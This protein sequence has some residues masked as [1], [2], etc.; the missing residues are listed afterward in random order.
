MFGGRI[1]QLRA[2]RGLSQTALAGRAGI[3][4]DFLAKVEQG[5][6]SP[7]LLRIWEIAD[8]LEVAPAEL[9]GEG[10]PA[11]WQRR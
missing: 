3:S 7:G 6:S 11:S 9:F 2:W 4:R 1:R 5:R 8:A 10:L